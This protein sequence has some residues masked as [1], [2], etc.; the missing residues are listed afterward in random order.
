[1]V[2]PRF[3]IAAVLSF[4]FVPCLL[5]AQP[6]LDVVGGTKLDFGNLYTG[7]GHKHNI[8]LRNVGTE[9]LV[10]S[11]VSATCG[12]T[13]TLMSE[14]D[15]AP[16]DSGIL[17]ISFNPNRLSGPVE[18]AVSFDAN[19]TTMKHVRI[20]FKANVLKALDVRPNY[21]VFK[22]NHDSAS[23]ESVVLKNVS[24]KTVH[25]L[26]V[27]PSTSVVHATFSKSTLDPGDESEIDL[28][29]T[30]ETIG[31]AK[32]TL[33]IQT[34]EPHVPAIDVRYFALVTAKSSRTASSTDHK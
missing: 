25:I 5:I 24:E 10:I 29:F 22:T 23:S 32:G 19:D 11:N 18:K 1:M 8:V 16:G 7:N 13:G 20:V 9:T 21:V 17:S 6:K 14:N 33:V 30:P 28:T 34:D 4:L 15:I 12:C 3:S 26:S 2:L 31:A 27:T